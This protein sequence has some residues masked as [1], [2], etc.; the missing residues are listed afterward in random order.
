M[1]YLFLC[2]KIEKNERH[3]YC[4]EDQTKVGANGELNYVVKGRFACRVNSVSVVLCR[5]TP[6]A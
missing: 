2:L 3:L 4:S 6:N 5:Q 1:H